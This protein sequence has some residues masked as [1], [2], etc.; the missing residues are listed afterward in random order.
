MTVQSGRRGEIPD[1]TLVVDTRR[2]AALFSDPRRRR[3]LLAF[4]GRDRCLSEVA[5]LIGMPLNLLHYHVERLL[6]AG[7]LQRRGKVARAG[8]PVQFYGAAAEAFFVPAALMPGKPDERL[9]RELRDALEWAGQRVEL[10]GFVFSKGADGGVQMRKVEDS[11]ESVAHE[12]WR[13]VRLDPAGARKLADE[14]KA[15]I[16]GFQNNAGKRARTY[17][18]HAA[19]APR[20]KRE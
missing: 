11:R 2:A 13:L 18:V 16:T 7:L 6:E 12:L 10:S 8:R 5:A 15:L 20:I 19:L 9:H 3:I 17:I 14:M 4:V 1:R